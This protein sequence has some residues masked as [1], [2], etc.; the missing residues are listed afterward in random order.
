M[1]ICCCS[2]STRSAAVM[3]MCQSPFVLA[4]VVEVEVYG[5]SS[6]SGVVLYCPQR[7]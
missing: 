6:D 2:N 1:T 7:C 3:I 4:V 5:Y